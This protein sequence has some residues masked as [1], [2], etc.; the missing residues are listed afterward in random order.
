MRK[1]ANPKTA[2]P[3]RRD[4]ALS[5]RLQKLQGAIDTLSGDLEL[6]VAAGLLPSGWTVTQ[7]DET[8]LVIESCGFGR[9]DAHATCGTDSAA[10]LIPVS[11]EITPTITVTP[12]VPIDWVYEA[13]TGGSPE[14]IIAHS[15]GTGTI[16][17]SADNGGGY[18]ET[19]SIGLEV[20]AGAPA[21][22]WVGNEVSTIGLTDTGPQ[23]YSGS[24]PGNLNFY[25]EYS[26]PHG[27]GQLR[28]HIIIPG[29]GEIET[30]Y[31]LSQAIG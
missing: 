7:S 29:Y 5:L 9:L 14:R 21:F 3:A 19:R 31:Y 18:A 17:V 10:R 16:E 13:P 22:E 28:M 8:R 30:F 1:Y 11:V 6:A 23:L 4:A 15:S 20:E 24:L 12:S 27:G 26:V 2:S 25:G